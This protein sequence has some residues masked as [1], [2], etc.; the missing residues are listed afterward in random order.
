[1]ATKRDY[2]ELLGVSRNSNAEEIK[3]AYRKLAIKYHPDKNPGD[4]AAE[5]HFK[6]ISEAYEVLSDPEKRAAYDRF[7][8][9]A[10]R[11]GGMPR[12]TTFHDPFEIFREVFGAGGGNFFESFFGVEASE[13]NARDRGSDLRYDLEISLEEAAF[14]AEKTISIRKLATC[15]ACG[16]TG[17]ETGSRAKICPSCRGQGQVVSSRGIFQISRTC[18]ACNGVGTILEN[19]CRQCHGEGRTTQSTEIPIKIPAG[20]DDGVRLRSPGK[21]DAGFRGGQPGDLYIVIHIK[22]HEIFEREGSDLICEMPMTFAT[23][24]L[25]GEIEVPTL[26]GKAMLKIPPGTQSGT[27]F[28]LKGHGMPNL[29]SDTPGNLLVRAKIEV[30][31]KL[32]AE[33]RRKLIEFQDLCNH[34]NQPILQRFLE[35][36]RA[37]FK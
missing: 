11:G 22:P 25:G 15:K 34:D 28:K 18:P 3:K 29:K 16:G 6:E 20:V 27:L 36:A 21:G 24:A 35:K 31:T 9:D 10:F 12:E 14:G 37:F 33:Q 17:S 13:L 7:G 4:K 2:Y 32:N 23:A 30:P 26:S 8:P 1:M 5:E 19:P